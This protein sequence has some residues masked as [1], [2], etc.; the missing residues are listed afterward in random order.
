VVDHPGGLHDPRVGVPVGVAA[1]L[2]AKQPGLLLRPA[3]E[4]NPFLLIEAGQV[5]MHDIVLVLAFHEVHP[6]HLLVAGEAAH[7]GA[8]RVGDLPQW[9]GGGDRQPQLAL[10]VAQQPRRELQ[11]RDIDV[12]VHPVDALDLE[13][14][15]VSKDI[16]GGAR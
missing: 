10:H 16:G 2:G 12:A 14:H 3:D 5:G 4:Q 15:V 6:R 11:L 8:E 7:G 9:G 1:A 13:H